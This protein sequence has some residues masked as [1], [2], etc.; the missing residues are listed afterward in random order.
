MVAVGMI[1]MIVGEGG[2]GVAIILFVAASGVAV[3]TTTTTNGVL[4]RSAVGIIGTAVAGESPQAVGISMHNRVMHESK[5]QK[6][7][8]FGSI[9]SLLGP[10]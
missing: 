2:S 8:F 6:A 4:V 9:L 10:P 3:T 5:A 7:N 1:A